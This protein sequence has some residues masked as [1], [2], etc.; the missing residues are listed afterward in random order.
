MESTPQPDVALLTGENRDTWA[1]LRKRLVSL[2]ETN[3]ESL[4]DIQEALFVVNLDDY[5]KDR[6]DEKLYKQ[7]FWGDKAQNRWFDKVFQIIVANNGRAGLNG[8]H[9][10]VDAVTTCTALDYAVATWVIESGWPAGLDRC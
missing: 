2:S 8:E 1:S 4:K 9:S 10:P 3:V 7:W 5:T 6:D